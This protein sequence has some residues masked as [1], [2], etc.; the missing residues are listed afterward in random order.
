MKTMPN[1]GA[2]ISNMKDIVNMSSFFPIDFNY[3]YN[4]WHTKDIILK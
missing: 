1:Q 4:L 2:R 3:F